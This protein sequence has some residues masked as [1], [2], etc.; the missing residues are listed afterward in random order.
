MFLLCEGVEN[1]SVGDR[2]GFP[3][4]TIPLPSRRELCEF[5]LRPLSET[6][7]DLMDNIKDEDGGIDRVTVYNADGVRISGSTRLDVLL[8]SNFKLVVNEIG[9]SIHVPDDGK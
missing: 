9:Y 3:V 5:T 4:L 1:I 6:V 8:R 2:N 7:K